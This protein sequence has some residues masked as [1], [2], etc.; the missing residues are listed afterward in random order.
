V[1][2]ARFLNNLHQVTLKV[3]RLENQIIETP[4]SG[5]KVCLYVMQM[6]S[7]TF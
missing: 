5:I 1:R 3:G 6:L 7:E 4:T 2:T